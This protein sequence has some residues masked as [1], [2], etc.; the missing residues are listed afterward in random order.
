MGH[1]YAFEEWPIDKGLSTDGRRV[2]QVTKRFI[3]SC[4]SGANAW[5]W[6]KWSR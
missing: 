6:A 4:H 3:V 1:Q 5:R 2:G